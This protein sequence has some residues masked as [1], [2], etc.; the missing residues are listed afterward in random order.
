MTTLTR[1]AVAEALFVSD[2]QPSQAPSTRMIRAEVR[3][4]VHPDLA[5]RRM[6][7]VREMLA[8]AG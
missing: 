4:L 6:G 1:A 2:L 3:R 5:V 8:A 7:W